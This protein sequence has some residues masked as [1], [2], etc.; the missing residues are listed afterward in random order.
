MTDRIAQSSV[1]SIDKIEKMKLIQLT[2]LLAL[3]W[4]GLFLS[5]A[6]AQDTAIQKARQ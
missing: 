2:A 1:P 3:L 5:Q 6:N 4:S